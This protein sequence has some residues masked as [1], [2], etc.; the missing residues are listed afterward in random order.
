MEAIQ[1]E[2]GTSR[3]TRA[4]ELKFQAGKQAENVYRHA[5]HGRVS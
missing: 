1:A 5:L 3:L 2:Y 4:C